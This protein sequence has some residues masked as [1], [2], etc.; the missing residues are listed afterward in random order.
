MR[1]GFVAAFI[2]VLFAML[3]AVAEAR[4]LDCHCFDRT[5]EG[6]RYLKYKGKSRASCI[7]ACTEKGIYCDFFPFSCKP[8]YVTYEAVQVGVLP[9]NLCPLTDDSEINTQRPKAG[10]H[11]G[12]GGRNRFILRRG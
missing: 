3:P 10:E 12:R 11:P 6:I 1:S 5:A 8:I 7:E 2:G 4:C 9:D